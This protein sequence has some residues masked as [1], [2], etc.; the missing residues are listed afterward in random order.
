[1]TKNDVLAALHEI[2]GKC[3]HCGNR[4]CSGRDS[5]SK[6]PDN[7]S[8]ADVLRALTIANR[9]AKKRRECRRINESLQPKAAG[10][11]MGSSSETGAGATPVAGRATATADKVSPAPVP[12]E[13]CERPQGLGPDDFGIN[14]KVPVL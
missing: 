11:G 6:L 2:A 4:S 9:A 10:A 14:T 13:L 8:T 1:M 3:G 12:G 5:H 7:L